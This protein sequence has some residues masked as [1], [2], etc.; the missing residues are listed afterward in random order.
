[1]ARKCPTHPRTYHSVHDL[2]NTEF[3]IGRAMSS[4]SAS[5]QPPQVATVSPMRLD[6][7]TGRSAH[8]P[9]PPPSRW[10]AGGESREQARVGLVVG[11]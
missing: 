5:P 10:Q 11:E 7:R 4:R 3:T 1:M 6:L 8:R 9:L 2:P